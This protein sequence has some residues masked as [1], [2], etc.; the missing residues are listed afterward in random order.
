MKCRPTSTTWRP[1]EGGRHR[2][3][4]ATRAF[5]NLLT[6]AGKK[7]NV[8]VV[9]S[10]LCGRLSIR[11]APSS[12]ERSKT[13]ARNSVARNATSRRLTSPPMRST[14]SCASASSSLFPTR[15]KSETSPKPSAASWKRPPSPRPPTAALRRSPT[16]SP[17]PIPSIRGSRTSS[18]SSRRT[19]SS[20]RPAA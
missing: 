6:A 15:P 1:A 10:D 11:V 5:A 13:R 8:C 16:R 14:T 12:I 7:T 3:D 18:P 2:C 4:I 17:P 19:S 20:S 9:I